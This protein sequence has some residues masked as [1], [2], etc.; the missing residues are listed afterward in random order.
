MRI[1]GGR[2]RGIP[3]EVPKGDSVRP[4]T[5]R[6]REAVFS[7]LAAVVEGAAFVD[8]FAGCGSY[9][10]EAISR[11]AATGAFVEKHGGSA[12]LLKQ[13]LSNVLKSCDSAETPFRV[14]TGDA[15]RFE[16]PSKVDL[17]FADPPYAIAAQVLPELLRQFDRLIKP[18]GLIVLELP[19]ELNIP[20]GH[21]QVLR[22]WGKKGR[23][24][25][26]VRLL[27]KS[28]SEA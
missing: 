2:A 28:P 13:N 3:L 25:P 4:A 18:S 24:Q 7:R 27:Q 20:Q 21:W 22:E 16:H 12:R 14:V 1:T 19:S 6:M 5:D 8:L 11:G 26:S 23:G 15:L 9:G 17:I 10:L